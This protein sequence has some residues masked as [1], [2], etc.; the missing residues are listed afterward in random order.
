MHCGIAPGRLSALAF[1]TLGQVRTICEEA[2]EQRR[3]NHADDN[4]SR[5]HVLP[6][7]TA[8]FNA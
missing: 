4:N 7:K 1:P 2:D 6:S 8:T 3:E 5:A